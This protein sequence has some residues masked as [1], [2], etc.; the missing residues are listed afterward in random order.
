MASHPSGVSRRRGHS[1]TR[2]SSGHQLREATTARR[3]ERLTLLGQAAFIERRLL[4]AAATDQRSA[5]AAVAV[6]DAVTATGTCW[7]AIAVERVDSG[8]RPRHCAVCRSQSSPTPFLAS[9]LLAISP[10]PPAAEVPPWSVAPRSTNWPRH[11]KVLA[12]APSGTR[13]MST[14]CTDRGISRGVAEDSSD[15]KRKAKNLGFA[16]TRARSSV[17]ERSLHTREVAGSSP[18]V[19]IFRKALEPGLS[20]VMKDF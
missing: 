18:A 15:V 17:G 8:A 6:L 20:R 12:E 4:G 9:P 7:A 3:A 13:L 14:P 10:R 1:R 5:A 11:G 19:P 2:S 16:G